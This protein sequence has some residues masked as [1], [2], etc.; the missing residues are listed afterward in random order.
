L[1]AA[2]G[3]RREPGPLPDRLYVAL[4]GDVLEPSFTDVLMP[5]PGGLSQAALESLLAEFPVPVGA[6]LTGFVPSV[7]NESLAPRLVHALGM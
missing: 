5:E 2:A 4:D 3:I 7:R 1:I 6:G